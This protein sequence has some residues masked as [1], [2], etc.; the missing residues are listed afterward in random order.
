[1][2]RLHW[3]GLTVMVTMGV[4]MGAQIPVHGHR[5]ARSVLPENTIASFE[6]AIEAGAEWIELDLWATKDNVL[7][8]THDA[9]MNP[10]ICQGPEGSERLIRK[11]TLAEVKQWDCGALG[12]PDFPK[13]RKL[14]GTRVPTFDEVLDL[15]KKHARFRFNVEIKSSMGNAEGMPPVEEYARM[16]VEAIRRKG[17]AE[18]VMIQSFDWRLVRA[19]GAIAPEMP[20]SALYP[21]SAGQAGWAFEKVAAEAG[22]KWVSVHYATVTAEKVKSAHAAGIKVIAWTANTEE[23]WAR[24]LAAGVDEIITD[25]PRALAGWLKAR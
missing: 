13:Q 7:V 23:V 4:A 11:M 1:M 25:D 12:N 24:L 15:A 9:A 18:R 20:R 16:V 10:R 22:T 21:A 5:G 17:L 8:V 3:T 6:E 14:P 19:A 2:T